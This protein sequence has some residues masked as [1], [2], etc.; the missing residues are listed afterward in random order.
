MCEQT[1]VTTRVCFPACIN[2]PLKLRIRVTTH[3]CT[4]HNWFSTCTT[5]IRILSYCV[6]EGDYRDPFQRLVIKSM[7]TNVHFAQKSNLNCVDEDH[8]SYKVR[9]GHFSLMSISSYVPHTPGHLY[10]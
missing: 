9:S 2:K 4:L 3:R 6:L 8:M 5:V 10:I 7:L 1:Y